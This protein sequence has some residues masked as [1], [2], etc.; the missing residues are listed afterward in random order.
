MCVGPCSDATTEFPCRNATNEFVYSVANNL[1]T[2]LDASKQLI[3]LDGS[4]VNVGG[5]KPGAVPTGT[6][7]VEASQ[8]G[9]KQRMTCIK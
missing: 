7:A 9:N 5:G 4:S 8:N 1:F 3:Y 6:Y 2:Y